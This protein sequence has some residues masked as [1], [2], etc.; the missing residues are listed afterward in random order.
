MAVAKAVAKAAAK[1]VVKAVRV[2]VGVKLFVPQHNLLTVCNFS[3]T[4]LR[5]SPGGRT[6]IRAV[7]SE[8]MRRDWAA[9]SESASNPRYFLGGSSNR[10]SKQLE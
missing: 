2:V 10:Y 6:Q 8:P 7:H 1:V 5:V 9:P 4:H 3:T